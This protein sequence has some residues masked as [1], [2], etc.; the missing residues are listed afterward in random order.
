MSEGLKATVVCGAG[1]VIGGILGAGAGTVVWPGVGTGAGAWKGAV[2][3]C[4]I[5]LMAAGCT[6]DEGSVDVVVDGPHGTDGGPTEGKD[7]G[8]GTPVSKK[9]YAAVLEADFTNP[10]GTLRLLE[11]GGLGESPFVYQDSPTFPTH[12][13]AVIRSSVAGGLPL[14]VVNR[15]GRDTVQCV[16]L[17]TGQSTE[18]PM[19]EG[20]NPQDV[21]IFSGEKAYVSLYNPT[22]PGDLLVMN[23]RSGEIT[24]RIDLSSY[25]ENGSPA[26]A[27]AM[28]YV[29]RRGRGF[30]VV[31]LQDLNGFTADKNGKLVW[32]DTTTDRVDQVTPLTGANPFTLAATADQ[33]L[34]GNA[35]TF[36]PDDSLGGV[37]AVS[38]ASGIS[39][40]IA[41]DDRDL[42]G[43]PGDIETSSNSGFVTASFIDPVTSAYRSRI[44]RFPLNPIG[45][46]TAVYESAGS[47]QDTEWVERVSG[48][49]VGDRDPGFPGV[50]LIGPNG[51]VL[52]DK[53]A[54]GLPPASIATYE[55]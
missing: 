50:L 14:C 6:N 30:A 28:V 35:G 44:F 27:A 33:V 39:Q 42:G 38:I 15:L 5:A 8:P 21:L 43:A 48:L 41:I 51:A 16:D 54:G 36:N 47:I 23:P 10:A 52:H 40:G 18:Y 32:I 24:T 49:L 19:G 2:G 29:E 3:G 13:D 46:A 12:S 4:A 11:L 9:P 7:A 26:E 20:T 22:E 53:L 31:A 1:G 45:G 55:Q 17:Q 37:E 34:V 25:A